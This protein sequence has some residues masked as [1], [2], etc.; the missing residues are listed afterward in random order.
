MPGAG[1][2]VDEIPARY[3]L[4]E[5]GELKT[6]HNP[7]TG[8]GPRAGYPPDAQERDYQLKSEQFKVRNIADHLKPALIFNTA[9]GALDGLPVVSENRVV[10]GGNGRTMALQLV[11]GGEAHT[12]PETPKKFIQKRAAQFGFTKEQ[13]GKFKAPMIVRTIRTGDDPRE[14]AGW[15]RRL[16]A[17]LS[18]Q[19]DA[20]RLAVSRAKFI[21][22]GALEDL[23]QLPDDETLQEFLS[24]SRSLP[25]VRGLLAA[26]VIDQRTAPTFIS[27]SGLLNEEGKKLVSD[28]LVAKLIPDAVVIGA[29]PAKAV[30]SVARS[31][32]YLLGTETLGEYNLVPSIGRAIR[33]RI[34]M[35]RTDARSLSEYTR[36]MDAFSTLHSKSPL[37][38][39]VLEILVQAELAPV[40]LSKTFRS[41]VGLAREGSSAQDGF[42]M[43]AAPKLS[44]LDA[45]TKAAKDAG[46]KIA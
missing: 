42:A 26:E 20:V 13:V 30:E 16:N 33:D 45:L 5:I 28:L 8:F 4:V 7:L 17:S 41:Y 37:D 27:P 15:S 24:S 31:A 29:Y 44:P 6:S 25:F 3:C 35:R 39:R 43:F 34:G 22:P 2:R 32:P 12:Q 18:Q 1:A 9:P 11:Y 21:R 10:L 40:K 38:Q 23:A 46:I 36:Q 14:L 19:V